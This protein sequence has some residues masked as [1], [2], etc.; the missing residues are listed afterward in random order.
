MRQFCELR[1][2]LSASS[3][4]LVDY[5]REAY[6]AAHQDSPRITF[7]RDLR[8]AVCRTEQDLVSLSPDFEPRVGGV[9]LGS[10]GMLWLRHLAQPEAA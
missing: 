8:G 9:I 2:G 10:C 4:V 5:W 6:E 7:D 1:D 3:Q